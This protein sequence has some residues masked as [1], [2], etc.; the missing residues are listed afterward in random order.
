MTITLSITFT[1]QVSLNHRVCYKKTT[2][3]TY[4]CTIVT[5]MVSGTPYTANINVTVPSG[6]ESCDPITFEG[7]VQPTC[8]PE[9]SNLNKTP[10]PNLTYTPD[11]P[12]LFWEA[13][14][15][16]GVERVDV[17]DGGSG[18]TPGGTI[19]PTITG[20]GAGATA[21]CYITNGTI[22]KNFPLTIT[23][24]GSGYVDGFY[25]FVTLTNLSSSGINGRVEVNIFGGEVI[26]AIRY[27]NN[28]GTG[29]AIGDTVT[30]D[31]STGGMG[32]LGSGA[33]LTLDPGSVET[34]TIDYCNVDT[35]GSG[36]ITVGVTITGNA[37][38]DIV[39][40]DCDETYVFGVDCDGN[41]VLPYS[42]DPSQKLLPGQIINMCHSKLLPDPIPDVKNTWSV[43]QRTDLCCYECEQTTLSVPNFQYGIYNYQ[44]INCISK[45][46][47]Q[48]SL[49]YP[50]SET[51]TNSPIATI[52]YVKGSLVKDPGL[53]S[54]PPI[55]CI[56]V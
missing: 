46:T 48:S 18:Y 54:T 52:C 28:G 16:P 17:I 21:T 12:C 5:G 35:E 51:P 11:N 15:A 14:C 34:G 40:V 41:T 39:L 10:F 2:D 42:T 36:Y 3:A 29:Y 4:T 22:A 43:E 47:E 33:V 7:Y 44:Y 31:T 53:N 8:E 6:T 37:T 30:L 26:S 9:A 24:P 50:I 13:I 56:L 1:P 55:N 38:L 49:I 45:K 32:G 23:N 25:T 27:Q 20:D 19:N